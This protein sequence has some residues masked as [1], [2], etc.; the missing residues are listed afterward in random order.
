MSI[1]S[2]NRAGKK[3]LEVWPTSLFLFRQNAHRKGNRYIVKKEKRT[4]ILRFYSFTKGL[5]HNFV[6]ALL[7][8]AISVFAGYMT[9]QIIRV[10]VDSVINDS[11]FNL[12]SFWQHRSKTWAGGISYVKISFYAPWRRFCS[13]CSR[14]F[15]RTFRA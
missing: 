1:P 14:A 4:T 7:T 6:L 5:R 12:P 15:P 10:T 13:R 9:P 11:P 2:G 8:M 3:Q